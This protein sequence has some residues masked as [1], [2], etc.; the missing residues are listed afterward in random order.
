MNKKLLKLNWTNL[1]TLTTLFMLLFFS[2]TF[3]LFAFSAEEAPLE[4]AA[5]DKQLEEL[6]NLLDS[7]SIYSNFQKHQMLLPT[8]Q[9]LLKSGISFED[10]KEIIENG[11]EK[12]LDAYSMKKVFEV[13]LEAQEEDLPTKP[14][15]NKVNEGLA[16][17]VQKSVIISAL[18]IEAENLKKAKEI[19]VEA[20]QAGLSLNN[21]E[22]ML[23]II[24]DSLKNEVPPESLSWLIKTGTSEGKSI[25]EITE[26]S[27]ELSYLSLLAY[28]LGLS[29]EKIS[30][31]FT[32]AMESSAGLE[33]VC[34]NVQRNLE[35]EISAAKI[36]LTGVVKPS[37]ASDSGI[38]SSSIPAP[39]LGSPVEP[40]GTPA[41]EAG[42]APV[43]TGSAPDEPSIPSAG[44]AP[45]PP[46][47]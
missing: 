27:E 39:T 35:A 3:S 12:S 32:R 2:F 9:K 43:E 26:I 10:T 18:A 11:I 15:I 42:E 4:E 31:L 21:G 7:S 37:A 45:P 25:E 19:L 6:K 40:G 33:E 17:N 5:I 41:Q 22:E 24:V 8:S 1:I 44:E 16:K 47:N 20:Q 28:D 29:P 30:L 34:V 23:K 38:L 13:I 14:L 36:E 46:E